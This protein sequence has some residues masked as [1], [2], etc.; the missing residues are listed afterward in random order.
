MKV[1]IDLEPIQE[2]RIHEQRLGVVR[3]LSMRRI[4]ASRTKAATVLA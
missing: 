3:R 4:I 2:E 1:N